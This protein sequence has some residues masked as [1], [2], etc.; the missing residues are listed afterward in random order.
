MEPPCNLAHSI[1]LH[2]ALSRRGG[3]DA[4]PRKLLG[5]FFCALPEAEVAEREGFEPS[6]RY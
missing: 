6:K 2:R 5:V 3:F 1:L 4:Q